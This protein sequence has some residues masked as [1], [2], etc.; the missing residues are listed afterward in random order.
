MFNSC[1]AISS[2]RRCSTIHWYIR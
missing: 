2:N 1:L